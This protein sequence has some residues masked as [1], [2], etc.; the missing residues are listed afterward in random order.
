MYTIP[1]DNDA[2]RITNKGEYSTYLFYSEH[3]CGYSKETDFKDLNRKY[4]KTCKNEKNTYIYDIMFQTIFV[5]IE[6]FH[7][8]DQLKIENYM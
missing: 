4:K 5:V 8:V 7:A 3:I 2:R 6:I 1:F